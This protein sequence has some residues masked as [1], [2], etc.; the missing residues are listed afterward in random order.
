M[1]L[2]LNFRVLFP[3][4]PAEHSAKRIIVGQNL[5]P[6][7]KN[8]NSHNSSPQRNQCGEMEEVELMTSAVRCSDP[9]QAEERCD[10]NRN[11]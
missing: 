10:H 5:P 9:D 2:L 1:Q 7:P 8:S 6:T 11:P 3:E 4:L